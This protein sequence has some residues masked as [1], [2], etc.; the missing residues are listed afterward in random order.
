MDWLEELLRRLYGWRNWK[1]RFLLKKKINRLALKATFGVG[2]QLSLYYIEQ[3]YQIIL[4]RDVRH[5]WRE[6]E[7]LSCNIWNEANILRH[8]RTLLHTEL[9]IT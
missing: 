1:R 3:R 6:D 4:H 7:P 9:F 5:W 8:Y 2:D